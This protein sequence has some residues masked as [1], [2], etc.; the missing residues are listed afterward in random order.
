MADEAML[1]GPPPQ[2]TPPSATA[3][4]KHFWE[5][6]PIARAWKLISA[7]PQED[8]EFVENLVLIGFESFSPAEMHEC[9]ETGFDVIPGMIKR[10]AL[11]YRVVAPWARMLIRK[12]WDNIYYYLVGYSN[13]AWSGPPGLVQRMRMKDPLISREFETE[14]GWAW[15]N[16]SCYNLVNFLRIYANPPEKGP[17]PRPSMANP[18]RSPALPGRASP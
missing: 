1:E 4:A 5:M 15:L 12:Y 18:I 7:N 16:W 11:H 6:G 10:G 17:I 13:D 3:K 9:I 8:P 2:W 14:K